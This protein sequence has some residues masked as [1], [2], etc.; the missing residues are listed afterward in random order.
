MNACV[1]IAPDW[2]GVR[3]GS[4][5]RSLGCRCRVLLAPDRQGV[6]HGRYDWR[7][8]E[9]NQIGVVGAGV[10]DDTVTMTIRDDTVALAVRL[11]PV[12]LTCNDGGVELRSPRLYE[13]NRPTTRGAASVMTRSP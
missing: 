3:H 9:A 6:R 10:S 4:C 8:P 12:A 5:V 1:L 2:Q 11:W 7:V 13:A